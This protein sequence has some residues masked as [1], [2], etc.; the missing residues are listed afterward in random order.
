MFN[1]YL[2]VPNWFRGV[3]QAFDI[4]SVIVSLLIFLYAFRA[5]KL[6]GQKKHLVFSIAFL[7]IGM[8][9][10]FKIA[11]VLGFY[12]AVKNTASEI[13]F[14]LSVNRMI[15]LHLLFVHIQRFFILLAFS[16][17]FFLTRKIKNKEIIFLFILLIFSISFFI[18]S[19]FLFHLMLSIVTFLL[20]LHYYSNYKKLKTKSSFICNLGF[21]FIFLSHLMYLFI[22]LHS[23]FYI[24][25][26]IVQLVAFSLLLYTL[27]LVR[28]K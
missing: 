11:D 17:L 14:L 3:D 8:S 25:A 13:S 26:E 27:I 2:I 4:F 19:Y 1:Y 16:M 22:L 23:Y 15:N 6:T 28:R 20:V 9:F 7:L 18:T 21:V 12:P 10:I 24:F 5:Y